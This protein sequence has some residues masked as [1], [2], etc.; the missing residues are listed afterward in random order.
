MITLARYQVG[1]FAPLVVVVSCLYNSAVVSIGIMK[2]FVAIAVLLVAAVAAEELCYKDAVRACKTTVS[3]Q[4]N[5]CFFFVFC[6]FTG[7]SK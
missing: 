4:G 7:G 6:F 5:C 3:K 2:V 1:E